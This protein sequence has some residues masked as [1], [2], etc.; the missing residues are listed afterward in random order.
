MS[1]NVR[2]IFCGLLLFP[3]WAGAVDGRVESVRCEALQG[4][5]YDPAQPDAAVAVTVYRDEGIVLATFNASQFRQDLADQGYGNGKHGFVYPVPVTWQT[6]DGKAHTYHLTVNGTDLPGSPQTTRT[7][8][9]KLNDTGISLCGT[10]DSTNG[11]CPAKDYP[12]QDGQSGRG[13]LAKAG[14]LSKQGADVAR[15]DYTK[16]A[17]DGSELPATATLGSGP[18]DWACTRD[19]VTGLIWEVKT[20]DGGIRDKDNTYNFYQAPTLATTVNQTGLC[21]AKDWRVPN[22]QALQSLVYYGRV[23]PVIDTDYFPNTVSSRFWSSSPYIGST[24]Y[25]WYVNFNYGN[26]GDNY[27]YN[28]SLAVR[29]VRG[30]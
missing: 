27:R 26:V 14:R 24:N 1:L 25:A 6:H 23:N 3:A 15:F 30:G 2:L 17:N 21:G 20:D 11:D 28:S 13:R 5:A 10:S 9:P 7:C 8:Y 19:N 4:W 16:I 29:L 12:G 18:Q 22:R